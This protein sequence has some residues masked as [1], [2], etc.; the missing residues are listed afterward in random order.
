MKLI[1][2]HSL[3]FMTCLDIVLVHLIHQQY[4]TPS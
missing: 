1:V 2:Y 4:V 3:F